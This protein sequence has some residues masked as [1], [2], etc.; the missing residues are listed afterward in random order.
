MMAVVTQLGGRTAIMIASFA[1]TGYLASKKRFDYLSGY[2]TAIIG[3]SFLALVLKLGIHRIRP[4]TETSLINAS[5]WSFPSGHAM[6][7]MIFYGMITYFLLRSGHSWRLRMFFVTVAGFIVVMI[8]LSRIYLQVHY[9]SDV[10]AG[11]AGG[12]FWLSICIT[13]L[14]AYREKSLRRGG[15][16]N[17]RR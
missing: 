16:A 17:E 5:G 8:G 3:G 15:A 1:V 6:M 7:S 14:E 11:Y 4:L 13:G 10:L 9:L 12:L 2:L